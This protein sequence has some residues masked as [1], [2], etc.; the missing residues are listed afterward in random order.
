MF[1][2]ATFDPWR[3]TIMTPLPHVSKP[4]A[5]GSALWSL[6]MVLARSCALTAVSAF[7][8]EGL[9]RQDNTGWHAG[10]SGDTRPRP[11]GAPRGGRR[12]LF[13]PC[14]HV[15][16]QLVA[17]DAVGYRS[18]G[19]DLG[20]PVGG[21]DRG[22]RPEAG[23]LLPWCGARRWPRHDKR[24]EDGLCKTSSKKRLKIRA[25]APMRSP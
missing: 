10:A 4:Q 5:I 14:A 24:G 6:G 12:D 18:R 22:L 1:C 9:P 8:A 23:A 3:S 7:W 17:G 20:R 19:H 2:Q 15:G 16:A 21:G 25:A 11:N 13:C